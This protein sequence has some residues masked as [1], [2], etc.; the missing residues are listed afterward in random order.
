MFYRDQTKAI[1]ALT[2]LL[3]AERERCARAEGALDLA[4]R[5]LEIAQNNFEW[6]RLRLNQIETER[7]AILQALV[8]VPIVPLAI[9][10]AETTTSGNGLPNTVG[11][12]FEDIGDD[13]ARRLGI[14]HAY[15][16]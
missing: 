15:E 11:F 9:E 8:K 6:A 3:A 5:Q 14:D 2:E 16:S 7:S 12:D 13:A 1:E 10:R 4:Q